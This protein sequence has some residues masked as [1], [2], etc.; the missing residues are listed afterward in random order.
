MREAH[1]ILFNCCL[2]LNHKMDCRTTWWVHPTVHPVIVPKVHCSREGA[3]IFQ[4]KF[5]LCL[6]DK[7]TREFVLSLQFLSP[8]FFFCFLFFLFRLAVLGVG[9]CVCVAL[10]ESHLKKLQIK[11]KKTGMATRIPTK[12]HSKNQQQQKDKINKKKLTPF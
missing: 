1:F 3:G 11:H 10:K 4:V 5:F 12:G 6:G 2:D 9:V 8:P 7:S